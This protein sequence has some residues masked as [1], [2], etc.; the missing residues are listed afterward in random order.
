MRFKDLSENLQASLTKAIAGLN[1]SHQIDPN[2][3]INTRFKLISDSPNLRS[4]PTSWTFLEIALSCFPHSSL[5]I[6]LD[7]IKQGAEFETLNIPQQGDLV[8]RE[9]RRVNSK[10]LKEFSD[11]RDAYEL[12]VTKTPRKLI[13][14]TF[15]EYFSYAIKKRRC[16]IQQA[17]EM[18]KKLEQDPALVEKMADET[19]ATET[20]DAAG[21]IFALDQAL[22]NARTSIISSILLSRSTTPATPTETSNSSIFTRAY[23]IARNI[24]AYK[25]EQERDQIEQTAAFA[26]SLHNQF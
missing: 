21:T 6:A 8:N 2:Q 3:D 20:K 5:E 10:L 25:I 19:Y 9:L 22:D 17:T 12:L 16:N 1:A 23:N 18:A 4:F 26:R 11:A 24:R 13:G 14:R 7:L 15:A